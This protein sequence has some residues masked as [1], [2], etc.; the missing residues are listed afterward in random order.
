MNH[1]LSISN[2]MMTKSGSYGWCKLNDECF[3][4]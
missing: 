1:N 4:W 3:R 2:V